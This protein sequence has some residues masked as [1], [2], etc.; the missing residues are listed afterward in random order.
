MRIV[1]I[2]PNAAFKAKTKDEEKIF[3]SLKPQTLPYTQALENVKKLNGMLVFATPEEDEAP[4]PQ[5]S[6]VPLEDRDIEELKVMMVE[7]KA[8]AKP[9]MTKE[10]VVAAIRAKLDEV[11]VTDA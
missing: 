11:E 7:V 2:E 3:A 9:K 5:S 6:F 4:A 10:E 1:K 8:E